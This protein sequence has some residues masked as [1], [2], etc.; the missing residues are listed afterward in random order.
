MKSL[1]KQF[2]KK[3]ILINKPKKQNP[4]SNINDITDL[5][6]PANPSLYLSS[7]KSYGLKTPATTTNRRKASF[8]EEKDKRIEQ[9]EQEVQEFKRHMI[10]FYYGLKS[11]LLVENV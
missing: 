7:E 8:F 1:L 6:S 4:L 10:E 11:T 5:R 2:I 3:K 9:K